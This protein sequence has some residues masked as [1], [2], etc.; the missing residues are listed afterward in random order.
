MIHKDIPF[1]AVLT[2]YRG[3]D[4]SIPNYQYILITYYYISLLHPPRWSNRQWPRDILISK[5]TEI[6]PK[7]L[8]LRKDYTLFS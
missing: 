5:T 1:I 4:Y 8:P 3:S 7:P 6:D 2:K